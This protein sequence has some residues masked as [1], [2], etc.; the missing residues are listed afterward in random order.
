MTIHSQIVPN[1][2]IGNRSMTSLKWNHCYRS[3]SCDAHP[4]KFYLVPNNGSYY[5]DHVG[6]IM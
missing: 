2:I 5:E 6:E 4:P 1:K 3:P